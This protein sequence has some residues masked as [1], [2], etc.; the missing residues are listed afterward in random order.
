MTLL[1]LLYSVEKFI[2]A[3]NERVGRAIAW[4]T[5]IMVLMQFVVVVMR[6]VFG[7]SSLMMQESIVYMHA[8]VFL[9]AA[10]Y[11][12]LHNGHVRV[13]IFYGD[14]SVKRKALVDLLGV[15]ILLWPICGLLFWVASP[16]VY[17][18][19]RVFEGSQEGSG[20]QAVF[21]LKTTILVFAGL[22]ALQGLSLVAKCLFVL[23]GADAVIDEEQ[24][25]PEVLL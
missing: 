8:F 4:L 3:L 5:L 7:L 25:E 6:Y 15:F 14:A 22:L 23:S 1:P 21:L 9:I 2:D 10:G 18:A 11:T 12:L 20:I 17:E 24:E 19:W 13:D 16:F